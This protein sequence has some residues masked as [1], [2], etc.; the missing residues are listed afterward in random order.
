MSSAVKMVLSIM[1]F[2]GAFYFFMSTLAAG[3][4]AAA[5]LGLVLLIPGMPVVW[6]VILLLPDRWFSWFKAREIPTGYEGTQD[7]RSKSR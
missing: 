5:L 7:R 6:L 4:Y 2:L 3:K 1:A